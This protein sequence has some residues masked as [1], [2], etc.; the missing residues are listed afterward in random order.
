[1]KSAWLNTVVDD[2]RDEAAE[3][4][5]ERSPPARRESAASSAAVNGSSVP[6]GQLP[7]AISVPFQTR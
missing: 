5:R 1:L 7:V 6:S 3:A 4:R 2:G